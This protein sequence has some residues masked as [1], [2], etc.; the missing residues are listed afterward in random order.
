MSTGRAAPSNVDDRTGKFEFRNVPPGF[1][2]LTG[3]R[4]AQIQRCDTMIPI[5]VDGTD[6]DG[7]ELRPVPPG[8][9]NGQVSVEGDPAFDVTKIGISL[10][11]ASSGHHDTSSSTVRKDGKLLITAITPTVSGSIEPAA[12]SLYQVGPVGHHGHHGFTVRSAGGIP[13]RMELAIAGGGWRRDQ[14]GGHE[15]EIRARGQRDGHAGAGGAHRSGPFHARGTDA[16]G[17]FTITRHRAGQLQ[18]LRVGQGRYQCR[19]VT[20]SSAP[21]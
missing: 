7:I 15:R 13:P 14:W 4:S 6:M 11:G 2:Y 8:D 3:D 5:E 17:K 16:T 1:I 20:P 10:D 19:D 12:G 18:A 21:V 9:I